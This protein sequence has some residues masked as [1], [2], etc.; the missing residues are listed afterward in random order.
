MA[1]LPPDRLGDFNYLER[2]PGVLL[3]RRSQSLCFSFCTAKCFYSQAEEWSN[4]TRVSFT[5]FTQEVISASGKS[6]TPKLI[7]I[8]T[9]NLN[10]TK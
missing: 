6:E 2:P 1:G 7:A 9:A 3:T 4:K 5:L 8:T 10:R